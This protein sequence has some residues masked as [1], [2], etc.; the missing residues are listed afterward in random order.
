MLIF[1][2]MCIVFGPT[3]LILSDLIIM[4]AF[5]YTFVVVLQ[6]LWYSCRL[7]ASYLILSGNDGRRRGHRTAETATSLTAFGPVPPI[8]ILREVSLSLTLTQ[9]PCLVLHSAMPA[10]YSCLL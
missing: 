2:Y 5:C 10:N 7:Y 1:L 6:L 8:L 9:T 4:Q 3:A